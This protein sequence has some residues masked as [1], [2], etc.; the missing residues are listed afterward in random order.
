MSLLGT[1]SLLDAGATTCRDAFTALV[2]W[3][4]SGTLLEELLEALAPENVE[5]PWVK[6]PAGEQAKAAK[7]ERDRQLKESWATTIRFLDIFAG[8][9]IEVPSKDLLIEIALEAGIYTEVANG[10]SIAEVANERAVDQRYVETV[11]ARVQRVIDSLTA[12]GSRSR[13]SS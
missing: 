13:L 10:R 5:L 11:V 12:G 7:E 1:V 6:A 8:T 9:K 3:R 4:F 2:V